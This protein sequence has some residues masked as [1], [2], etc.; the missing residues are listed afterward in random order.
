MATL[1]FSF[2][3]F[4]T[5]PCGLLAFADDGRVA[6]INDTLLHLLG[7]A[8][9]EVVGRSVEALMP[10]PTRIFYQTHF[11]PLVTLHGRAD[12]ISLALRGKSGA[13]VALFV[14]AVRRETPDGPLVYCA[15]FAVHER[16]KYE[17]E[18]LHAKKTAEAALARNV[19]LTRQLEKALGD[20]R[21]AQDRLVHE[22]KLA[23]LGRL[24]ARVSHELQNPLNFVINFSLLADELASSLRPHLAESDA[25]AL[26]DDLTR[27]VSRVVEHGRR[28]DAIV[29]G[30]REHAGAE[31]EAPA[32]PVGL[33]RLVERYAERA[34]ATH[35]A[36]AP[37]ERRYQPRAG[38]VVAVPERLGRVV[39]AL[40]TNALDAVA[41]RARGGDA[42]YRPAIGVATRRTGDDVEIV[43]TDNGGGIAPTDRARL[44]EPLFTTRSTRDGHAG[45]SLSL[46]YEIVRAHG[47]TISIDDVDEGSALTVRLPAVDA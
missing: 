34:L 4:E 32:R 42:A 30:M 43:V 5:A 21:E 1:P 22:E 37:M 15:L 18:L 31:P 25:R 35:D 26:L 36:P 41:E 8:R 44:F 17:E 2:D 28:A 13:S 40:V 19:A 45:L 29:R 6:R 20:L 27:N 39:E 14:N 47:G 46:A 23:S 38:R 16:R 33:N 3:P 11:F 12:E 24:T 10:L 7:Y 9:D